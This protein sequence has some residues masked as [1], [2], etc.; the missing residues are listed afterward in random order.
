MSI[1][2]II[3][4]SAELGDLQTFIE[5]LRRISGLDDVLKFFERLFSAIGDVRHIT[6][7]EIEFA[8]GL[9]IGLLLWHFLSVP[10]SSTGISPICEIEFFVYNVL[11][12]GFEELFLGVET[13]VEGI[14]RGIGAVIHWFEFNIL[15]WKYNDVLV[16]SFYGQFTN[17][18]V[19]QIKSLSD[20]DSLHWS[21]GISL[22]S[23]TG[24]KIPIHEEA[25]QDFDAG[26]KKAESFIEKNFPFTKTWCNK[27][28]TEM[29]SMYG[30]D[31]NDL[32][33][34]GINFC[35]TPCAI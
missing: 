23:G 32:A 4:D 22:Y 6:A 5:Q 31:K 20:V 13:T 7:N 18:C 25:W 27:K 19:G 10:S 28:L 16:A 21:N 3:N 11:F 30:F 34:L 8:Y 24:V 15:D 14:I 17:P 9:L 12:K 26:T 2:N 29:K 35:G 33:V 1:F